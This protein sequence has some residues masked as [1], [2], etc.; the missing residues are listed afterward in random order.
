MRRKAVSAV[1][2]HFIFLAISSCS[3]GKVDDTLGGN[4]TFFSYSYNKIKLSRASNG[5]WWIVY[6]IL[7]AQKGVLHVSQQS[8]RY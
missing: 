8:V 3:N 6:L 5:I 1:L 7:K 4:K 2:E